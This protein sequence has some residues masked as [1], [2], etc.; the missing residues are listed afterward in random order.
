MG[1]T[2][3]MRGVDALRV[4]LSGSNLLTLSSVLSKYKMD[5]EAVSY[6]YPAARS[7]CAGVQLTF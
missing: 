1:Y 2:I 4:Y 5:P 7:I 6:G 3:P